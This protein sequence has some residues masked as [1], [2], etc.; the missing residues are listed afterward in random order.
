MSYQ[1]TTLH[2]ETGGDDLLATFISTSFVTSIA[3]F[4]DA[5]VSLGGIKIQG[6]WDKWGDIAK[7]VFAN[8]KSQAA[9]VVLGVAFSSRIIGNPVKLF[10]GIAQGVQDLVEKPIEGF[11]EG[12]LAG[13]TGLLKG[14][15]SLAT[16]T[17]GGTFGVVQ[18]ITGSLA[19]GISR[20]AVVIFLFF[21]K[22]A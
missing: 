2:K 12:P 20:L 22:G 4:E 17:L 5:P 3:S 11:S 21:V 9:E 1:H 7:K 10:G 13:G 18:N 8:Y 15:E 6:V 14:V 19:D 16:K